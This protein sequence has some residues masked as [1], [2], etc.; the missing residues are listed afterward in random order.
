MLE[1]VLALVSLVEPSGIPSEER[2]ELQGKKKKKKKKK[3]IIITPL[4]EDRRG[5]EH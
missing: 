5:W 4:I 2:V 3:I 1:E